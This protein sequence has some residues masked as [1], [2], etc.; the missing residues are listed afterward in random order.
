MKILDISK[1]QPVVDYAKTAKD[2]DGVILHVGFTY[3]EMMAEDKP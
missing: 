2:I 1:W 3:L